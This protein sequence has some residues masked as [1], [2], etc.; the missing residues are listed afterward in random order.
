MGR[1]CAKCGN[2]KQRTTKSF[3]EKAIL[4]HKGKYSYENVKYKNSY[5]N[6][7]ITCKYH[8]DFN[9]SPAGHLKGHNCPK[10]CKT[11]SDF[12]VLYIWKVMDERWND[13]SI[14]K[15]GAT[16]ER[17]GEQRII[18]VSNKINVEYDM[19]LYLKT[20]Q[21]L[22]IEKKLHNQFTD[23]PNMGEV[24]GRTEF[25]VVNE[26]EMNEVIKGLLTL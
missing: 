9:Q 8:G 13:K 6:V 10:C 7:I 21:A 11:S 18:K 3:I 4:T 17:L 24:D 20:E 22:N 14:Y 12:N 2:S 25:R 19:C 15:I 16:S 23:I 1:G 26:E 5:T